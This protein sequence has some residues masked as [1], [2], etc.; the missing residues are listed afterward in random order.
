[1]RR[2]IPLYKKILFPCSGEKQYQ[3]YHA[4]VASFK[5]CTGPQ[6]TKS[7]KHTLNKKIPSY[8]IAAF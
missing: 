7:V 8:N 1:M 3:S 2:A 6:T 5:E 4:S